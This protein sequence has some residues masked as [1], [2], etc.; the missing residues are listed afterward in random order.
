MTLANDIKIFSCQEPQHIIDIS[1][2]EE[3]DVGSVGSHQENNT[4]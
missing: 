4:I 3:D 1:S 2:S